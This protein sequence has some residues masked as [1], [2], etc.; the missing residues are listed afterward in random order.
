M[1]LG[2]SVA[3][4][5]LLVGLLVWKPG[6]SR[7][8]AKSRPALIVYCAAGI[9]VPVE[10][11]ARQYEHDYGVPV[12]LQ[13]G[14]S[15]TLL[16][17]VELSKRG[18]LYLPADESYIALAR[19]K[20]LV[21]EVIPLARMTGVLAVRKGNP[22]N[23]RSLDDLQRA[24]VSVCQAN[25]DAA[26]IGKA[27]RELLQKT[28]QWTAIEKRTVVF[29][30]TVNDVAND[31]KLG[32]V[33]AG[34][35]WDAMLRLY[36]ELEAVPVQG[37][38]NVTASIAVSVIRTSSQPTAA[39]KFARYLS[40]RDKG[41][42]EFAQDGYV[43][44][45]GDAWAEKP[46]LVLYSG[47]M[48]R[49]AVE[50]TINQ[51]EHRE[52]VQVTRVFN[53]CGI[54][55]AQMKAGGRPDAY[56]TCDKSFVPPVQELFPEPPLEMSDS[57]IIL[58]VPKGNPK[59][60]HTLADLAAPGLRIGLANAEQSTLG[61]LTQRLLEQDGI[62]G[63]V[64]KNVVTQT[65]TADLLV[66]Q[67]RTGALDATVVY[68]SNTTKVREQLDVVKIS[69]PG[70]VAVQTYSVGKDSRHRR[71]AGRLRDALRSSESRARYET[72]GFHWRSAEAVVP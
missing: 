10:A 13:Y 42:K 67:M 43:P 56:L 21:A 23:I 11:V 4:A 24:D 16:A 27:T 26:A 18:D 51:F 70:S 5:I 40:A 55:V 52:G 32:T 65:P 12:Q 20:G 19:E 35:I 46:E 72:A 54:L 69:V 34:F 28:G 30:P 47:A 25:P 59:N 33:D 66:N 22:K 36:P 64:M 53:G 44:A 29:K 45:D 50:E 2:V 49:V 60:L 8:D 71:L 9:K 14:G 61:A 37:M 39:L 63:T 38:T 31:L 1:A 48:N 41:L 17:N 3:A 7:P 15:Q 6:T 68:I 57:E 58:L 62:L